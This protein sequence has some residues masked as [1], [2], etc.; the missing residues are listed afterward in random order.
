M[1]T[2]IIYT[3]VHHGNTEKIAQVMADVLDADLC[4]PSEIRPNKILDYDLFGFG[5]GIYFFKHHRN[6]L[7]LV[8][9]LHDLK[10]KSAFI[11]STRGSFPMWI[12]HCA[13][14][15]KLREKGFDIKREFSCKG[16]DTYGLL[17][18]TGGINKGRPS[19][20]DL[21]DAIRFAEG[22]I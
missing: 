22:L 16:Y 13:L 5:S 17:K 12:G 14:K 1:Q 8:D 21:D 3:S 2:L 6:I 20:K 9:E 19:F 7:A 15:K 11:F 10:G 18:L 4:R